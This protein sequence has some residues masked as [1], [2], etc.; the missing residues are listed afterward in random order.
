M[1]NIASEKNVQFEVYEPFNYTKLDL[2]VCENKPINV[3]IQSQL[4]ESSQKLIEELEKLGFDVFNL[5]SPFYTDFCTK[6]TTEGG[7]DISLNDRKKYIYDQIM[8]GVN[9]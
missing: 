3:Y 2:S 1:T 8:N 6:Y 5:N 7:T 4:S 9:C